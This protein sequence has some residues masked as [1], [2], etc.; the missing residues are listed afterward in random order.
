[1]LTPKKLKKAPDVDTFPYDV[2]SDAKRISSSFTLNATT[3]GHSLETA[4]NYDNL[5]IR[6]LK[7]QNITISFTFPNRKNGCGKPRDFT[8][9]LRK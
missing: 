4:E 1:M 3:G 9:L 6:L 7:F 8:R 2:P 5:F